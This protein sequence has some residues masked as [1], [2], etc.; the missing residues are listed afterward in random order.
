MKTILLIEDRLEVLEN[1]TEYLELKGFEILVA[2]NGKAGIEIAIKLIPDLIICDVL[3]GDM[4]GY[5]VLK[6]ISGSLKTYKIPFVFSTSISERMNREASLKL[7]AD[8]YLIKP[9]ELDLLLKTV[10]FWIASGSNR[11]F[12]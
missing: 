3:M 2:N 12:S 9:F 10:N 8:D 5:E 6:T 1:L 4:D 11:K 7:G